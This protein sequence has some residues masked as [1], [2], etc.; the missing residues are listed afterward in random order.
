MLSDSLIKS[1]KLGDKKRHTDR[2]GLVL[3]LRPS[4]KQLKKIFI[5]VFSGIRNRKP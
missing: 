1:L 4:K 3:E 2:D 5:F